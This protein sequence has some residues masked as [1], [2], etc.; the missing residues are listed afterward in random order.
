[1]DKS[2]TVGKG[3]A[4]IEV[5]DY[6]D[7]NWASF[8]VG[9]DP[10]TAFAFSTSG[11]TVSF[12][13]T[14]TGV[15]TTTGLNGTVVT[16]VAAGTC[17]ITVTA[18]S[19]ANYNAAASV[20]L[21]VTVAKGTQTT[22]TAVASP[23]HIAITGASGTTTL[24]STGGTG[25]GAV[26]YATTSTG[27]TIATT[28]LTATTAATTAGCVVTATKAADNDYEAISSASITIA[29]GV[30]PVATGSAAVPGGTKAA[31]S[32]ISGQTVTW[33]A[34]PSSTIFYQWYLCTVATTTPTTFLTTE[35]AANCAVVTGANAQNYTIPVGTVLTGKFW[36]L[37]V[38]ATNTI[39]GTSYIG[40]AW[41]LTK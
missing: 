23:T 33:T 35:T 17:N 6:P 25:T 16:I 39:G 41:T 10:Y 13:S 34:T 32:T 1:V 9:D 37:R 11:A 28:T 19:T 4:Y 29:V 24:S 7:G 27:C 20:A 30:K 14:T 38:R 31:G 26:T 36:R 22:L 40:Y 15:C 3:D 12:A 5:A 18:P 2:F 8:N 21:S